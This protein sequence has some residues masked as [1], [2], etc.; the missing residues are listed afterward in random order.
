MAYV[1]RDL[2]AMSFARNYHRWI[3]ELFEPYLGTRLVEV[4]AGT[5]L[6]SALILNHA[7]AS[8]SLVEPSSAMYA[9]LV[10]TIRLLAPTTRVR[11]ETHHAVFSAVADRIRA[12][13][14]PDSIIYV[15]VLEHIEDDEG[16]LALV[17]R[18]LVD[19]GRAFL[20]VPALPWLHGSYDAQIGHHRRYT[21][22]GLCGK[23]ERAGFRIVEARYLDTLGVLP[24]W[25]KY[26]ALRSQR[27]EAGAVQFY[28]NYVVPTL[29]RVEAR[30]S[31][32]LGKNLLVI[33]Q[34]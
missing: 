28:D 20:F 21:R 33:V 8:L 32:P 5:G 7:A 24:W 23:C 16:E 11:V 6:F 1:G 9:Q 17:Y 4:G 2:E 30:V 18:T 19:G 26:W 25:I 12:E 3:L 34:K 13:Q 31:P 22:A 15:N 29:K 14:Q 27:M 10:E